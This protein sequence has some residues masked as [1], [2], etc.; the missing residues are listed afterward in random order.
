M[1]QQLLNTIRE[2]AAQ[3]AQRK[4]LVR[5]YFANNYPKDQLARIEHLFD[6]PYTRNP[7]E[8]PED[9]ILLKLNEE[10]TVR[11]CIVAGLVNFDH[12]IALL[13][14]PKINTVVNGFIFI[15]SDPNTISEF[16]NHPRFIELL[17]CPG[18][19][20]LFNY[21]ERSIKAALF[22]TLRQAEYSVIMECA[23]VF[24]NIKAASTPEM[25]AFYKS[26][27]KTYDESLFHIYHNYGR[28]DDSLEGVRA[29]FA[30]HDVIRNS[31]SYSAIKNLYK[32][33]PAFI[34]AAGP[35][36]DKDIELIKKYENH[37]VVVCA[38]AAV[39][40]LLKAG[41]T[42][43]YT[44]SIERGNL[45]QKPFWE[46]L[47]PITTELVCY[48][49]VH[50]DVLSIYPG[51]KRICYRNYSY[52]GY[53]DFSFPKGMSSSG[54]STT[55]LSFKLAQ[56]LGCSRFIF[57]GV[58]NAYEEVTPGMFKSHCNNLGHEDWADLK[59]IADFSDPSKGGKHLPPFQVEA[60]DGSLVYTNLTYN[61]WA[62][63]FSND[64]LQENLMDRTFISNAKSVKFSGVTVMPL[65]DFCEKLS[66]IDKP[67]N[68]PPDPNWLRAWNH[69][70]LYLNVRGWFRKVEE[71]QEVITNLVELE[72]VHTD[73]LKSC[74]NLIYLY[75]KK[76]FLFVSFVIQNCAVEFYQLENDW[77]Y[78]PNDPAKEYPKR[79]EL[80]H[81]Q[82]SLYNEVLGKLIA[83]L[84][85]EGECGIYAK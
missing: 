29:T 65:Q 59:P 12:V 31:K 77:N 54:G 17:A 5:E 24:A 76:D 32:D 28:I 85:N 36:L 45:Y 39:K 21:D 27:E 51:P 13:R 46:N 81:R 84:E 9:G 26:I 82:L 10:H 49:V 47:G 14:D 67:R 44:T 64:I 30:N 2:A 3:P 52:Y 55:H 53:F 1:D 35:S 61:Q 68:P 73:I 72:E 74:F 33:C 25:L 48:P 4:Q 11:L 41:I 66:V 78:L 57:I 23:Q 71:L 58:D 38:D 8:L 43:D 69:K 60:F 63:E 79:L 19:R 22:A 70:D 15:E 42:P 40:P 80:L 75:F 56:H 7:Q 37:A 20:F 18:F 16:L 62:Q 6:A 50:P 83:I 34:V